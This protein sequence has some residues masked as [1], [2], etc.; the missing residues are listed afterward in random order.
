MSS[1]KRQ[2][3][4]D[5]HEDVLRQDADLF[6]LALSRE[7]SLVRVIGDICMDMV[8]LGTSI[9]FCISIDINT[10]TIVSELGMVPT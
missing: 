5:A 1:V 9:L 6:L 4:Y 3:A 2:E 7:W 8:L 10:L